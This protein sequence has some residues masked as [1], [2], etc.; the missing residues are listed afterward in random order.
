MKQTPASEPLHI[1][2][3]SSPA[4]KRLYAAKDTLKTVEYLVV[5]MVIDNC[6]Q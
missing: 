6:F 1:I 3:K 4:F 2:D 5:I